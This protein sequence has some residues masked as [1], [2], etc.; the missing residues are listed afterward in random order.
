M[1]RDD[2]E[3]GRRQ[4]MRDIK[5]GGDLDELWEAWGRRQCGDAY[6]RGYLHAMGVALERVLGA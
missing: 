2:Y 6:D 1:N 5:A 4:A 3:R